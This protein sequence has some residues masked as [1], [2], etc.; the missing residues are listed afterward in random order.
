MNLAIKFLLKAKRNTYAGKGA[1]IE[2]S[3]PNAHDLVYFEGDYKYIDSYLGGQKFA[4]EE[5]VFIKDQPYWSMNYYGHVLNDSFDGDFLKEALLH[6]TYDMPY[7][8]PKY[9]TKDGFDYIC[10]ADGDFNFFHG[11]EEIV[12]DGKKIFKCIF[13]GGKI[14]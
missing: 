9:F 13:H 3:K 8:G 14:E 6:G 12:K 2:P 5:A 1:E 7:R 4:G 10:S 11:S